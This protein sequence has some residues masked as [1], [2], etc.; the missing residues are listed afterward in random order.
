MIIRSTIAAALAVAGLATAQSA[1]AACA[2]KTQPI[3]IKMIVGGGTPP[4]RFAPTVT[5]KVNGKTGQFL[6]DS[7]SVLNQMST[8]FASAQRLTETKA[9]NGTTI[10]KAGK[11]EFSGAT[12]SDVPFVTTDRT[13]VDGVVGQPFLRKLDVEYDLTGLTPSVKLAQAEGCEGV[14]MAYWAKDGQTYSEMPLEPEDKDI[15]LTKTEV[16]I[17]G[18]K[19][20][21]MLDTGAPYT[22]VTEK[23]AAKA[24]VKVGDASVKPLGTSGLAWIGNFSSVKI[25]DEEIKNAP[26]E[27]G[28]T[29]DDYYDVLLGMDFL[30]AHH[31]YVAKSQ[32]KIFMTYA[33]LPGVPVFNPHEAAKTGVGMVLHNGAGIQE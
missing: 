12:L 25:G 6:L 1:S 33:G 30:R 26:I 4:T 32:Q 7:S 11:F 17:N 27:I 23:A 18:V 22:I 14:N 3:A 16:T 2:L 5:A 8:K 20:I 29:K 15:P 31:L 24:G 9:A 10:V 21:A 28:R 19:L 13:D